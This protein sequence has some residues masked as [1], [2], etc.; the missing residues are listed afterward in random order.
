MVQVCWDRD[1]NYNQAFLN[2]AVENQLIMQSVNLKDVFAEIADNPSVWLID[3]VI[4]FGRA[5]SMKLNCV[6]FNCLQVSNVRI[7]FSPT[8]PY[9]RFTARG[10]V[11]TCEVEFTDKSEPFV[12]FESQRPQAQVCSLCPLCKSNLILL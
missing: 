2:A 12:S 5:L 8:A 6:C 9:I 1:V 4:A 3:V 10:S 7:A 11:M